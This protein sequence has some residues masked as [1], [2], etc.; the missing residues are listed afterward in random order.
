MVWAVN[1]RAIKLHAAG[2]RTNPLVV[3]GAPSEEVHLQL[4]SAS[5]DDRGV[6]ERGL[7]ASLELC[8]ASV[9]YKEVKEAMPDEG[10]GEMEVEVTFE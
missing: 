7:Q 2:G 10:E 4:G 6:R 3:A 5:L 9:G 8:C 1:A